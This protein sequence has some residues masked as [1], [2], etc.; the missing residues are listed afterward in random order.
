MR[1]LQ[2]FKEFAARGNLIDMGVGIVM[3]VSF[4]KITNS[5]VGD[6]IMP[7]LGLMLGRVNFA[8]LFIALDGRH[9]PSLAAAKA[10]G[11]PILGIGVF[12][13]T[14]LD[15]LIVAFAMFLL[16]RTVNRFRTPPPPANTK[17]CPHCASTIPL[18]ATRCPQCTSMLA[19]PAARAPA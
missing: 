4:G 12:I 10:A 17:S 14:L 15:F 8:D 9:Y 13:N 16:V 5:L 2:E 7:P 11:A 6:I 3:G 18:A 1:M 19:A